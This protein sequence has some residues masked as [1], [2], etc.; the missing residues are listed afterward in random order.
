[1]NGGHEHR[2]QLALLINQLAHRLFAVAQLAQV[3]QAGFQLAQLYIV[4]PTGHFL[5]VAGNKGHRRAFVEQLHGGFDLLRADLYF[6]RE[7]RDDFLHGGEAK[8]KHWPQG[9]IG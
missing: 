1:M 5:A 3:R 7:L 8:Q 6:L 4:Q 9:Q 2:G